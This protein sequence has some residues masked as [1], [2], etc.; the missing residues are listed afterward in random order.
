MA[1]NKN[2]DPQAFI[3]AYGPDAPVVIGEGGMQLTLGQALA[4]EALCPAS[5]DAIV[6]PVRRVAF[7][8]GIL[9]AAGTLREEH[10]PLVASDRE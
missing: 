2:I 9:A 6:D 8:A 5:K 7:L 3:Q 1:G 4:A 10:L